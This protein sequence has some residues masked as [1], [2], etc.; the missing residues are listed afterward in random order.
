MTRFSAA[1]EGRRIDCYDCNQVTLQRITTQ[2]HHANVIVEPKAEGATG[3]QVRCRGCGKKWKT[4]AE[5]AR[6]LSG[7]AFRAKKP[8]TA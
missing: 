4:N 2:G 7:D 6:V 8:S 5:Y 3:Y 1:P